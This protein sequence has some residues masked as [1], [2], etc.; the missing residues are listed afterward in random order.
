MRERHK[1]GVGVALYTSGTRQLLHYQLKKGLGK[2]E[3]IPHCT[4]VHTQKA[5]RNISLII[6]FIKCIR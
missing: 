3:W 4:V 2:Q 1:F 5:R 6:S